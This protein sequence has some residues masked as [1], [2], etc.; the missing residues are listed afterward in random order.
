MTEPKGNNRRLQARFP[1]GRMV[2]TATAREKLTNADV[3]TALGRHVRGDWGDVDA[4]DWAANERAL[5]EETRLVSVYR[6]SG[7]VKFY[8]ITEH[9]RSLTTILLPSDY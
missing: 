3:F 4:E 9:D 5:E 8:I 6:S 1:L 2:I 7:G